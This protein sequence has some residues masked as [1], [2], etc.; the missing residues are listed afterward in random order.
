M[1][2]YTTAVCGLF[3]RAPAVP[4]GRRLAPHHGSNS[5]SR[6]LHRTPEPEFCSFSSNFEEG[7]GE[8]DRGLGVW[9]RASLVQGP[10][11]AMASAYAMRLVLLLLL[12]VPCFLA[13]GQVC[14]VSLL[15][16]VCLLQ[17]SGVRGFW[18][19][20]ERFPDW[21]CLD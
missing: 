5:S 10:D 11:L 21:L 15:R 6:P 4:L 2:D 13:Q 12:F 16:S 9:Q 14:V 18:E 19:T 8:L 20:E 7:H 1:N 3:G 17:C